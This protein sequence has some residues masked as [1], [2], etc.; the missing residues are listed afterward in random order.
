MID[1]LSQG[2]K[3]IIYQA[4]AFRYQV[5]IEAFLAIN[6]LNQSKV[7]KIVHL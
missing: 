3:E 6:L 2:E 1:K 5:G 7:R 4:I